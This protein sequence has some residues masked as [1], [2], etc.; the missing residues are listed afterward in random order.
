ME[1]SPAGPMAN[2]RSNIGAVGGALGWRI[3]PQKSPNS[4]TLARLLSHLGGGGERL[5]SAPSQNIS[6]PSPGRIM[7]VQDEGET[8]IKT[9]CVDR[10]ISLFQLNRGCSKP[11]SQSV[12]WAGAGWGG[13]LFVREEDHVGGGVQLCSYD[14]MIPPFLTYFFG[15]GHFHHPYPATVVEVLLFLCGGA[16]CLDTVPVKN[17]S[18]QASVNSAPCVS[19]KV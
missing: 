3:G 4:H 11:S 14:G 7:A 16:R 10:L 12:S 5:L 9:S 6:H 15:G 1:G 13:A 19:A 17:L 18:E 2:V 8:H